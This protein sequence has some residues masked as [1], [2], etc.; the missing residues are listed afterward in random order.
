MVDVS[1][2]EETGRGAQ[3]VLQVGP[4]KPSLNQTLVSTYGAYVLP[5]GP[6][7]AAFLAE[8]GDRVTVAVTS[9]R[10]G[11]DAE[12]MSALPNLGAVVNFGVGYDTTDVDAP[13]PVTSWSATPRTCSAT[14]SPTP[15][16]GC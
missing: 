1:A 5:D 8:H 7:R 14:A 16:S 15:R 4:L 10:T 12:L 6:G 13:R 11:V 2:Q 9:G 3:G